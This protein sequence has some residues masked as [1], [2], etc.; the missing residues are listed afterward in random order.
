MLGALAVDLAWSQ[1]YALNLPA[2]RAGFE[3]ILGS[4]PGSQEALFGLGATAYLQADWALVL[5]PMES[6]VTGIAS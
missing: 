1:L 2:A 4:S 3:K 5:V 6:T